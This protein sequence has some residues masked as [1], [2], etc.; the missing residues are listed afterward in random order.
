M[1]APPTAESPLTT[2]KR[3]EEPSGGGST[4]SAK[5]NKASSGAKEAGAGA[6]AGEQTPS[7]GLIPPQMNRPNIVTE[8]SSL[9]SSDAAVKRKRLM[10]AEKRGAAKGKGAGAAGGKDSLSFKQREK[11]RLSS[12]AVLFTVF[13]WSSRWTRGVPIF[14]EGPL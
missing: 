1:S 9:W 10:E 6:G 14:G 13:S 11:V 7:R 3:K 12:T 5:R 8:D 4:N 2:P